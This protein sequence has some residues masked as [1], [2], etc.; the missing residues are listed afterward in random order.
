MNMQEKNWILLKNIARIEVRVG[1]INYGGHMGNDKA[2]LVFQDARLA[3]LESIGFSEK[4][5]GGPAIIMRDAYITFRKEVFLHDSLTVDVG[6]DNV[7]L[8]SFNMVYTVIRES[9]GVVVFTGS[10]GLVAFD[11]EAR[12]VAKLP[13]AFLERISV[14]QLDK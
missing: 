2:L 9:D 5:I 4:N 11:Y 6:I 10:T 7:T 13:E 8:T 12:K 3:F 14:G 1:D